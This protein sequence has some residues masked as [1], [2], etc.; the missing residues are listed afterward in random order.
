MNIKIKIIYYLF[1]ILVVSIF[2]YVNTENLLILS[3]LNFK[4]IL[5][6]TFFALLV[7]LFLGIQFNISVRI[8]DIKLSFNEWFGLT[9]INSMLSYFTPFR[10]GI[11]ARA[12][13]LKKRY[14]LPYP[15]QFSILCCLYVTNLCIASLILLFLSLWPVPNI[16]ENFIFISFVLCMATILTTVCLI[17][18]SPKIPIKRDNSFYRV[19]DAI[20]KGIGIFRNDYPAVVKI[21]CCQVLIIIFTGLRLY[22]SFKSLNIPVRLYDILI[23]QSIVSFSM[24]LSITPGNLGIKEGI[25]SLLASFSNISFADA[26]VAASVDRIISLA[27]TFLLGIIF[28]R[29]LIN[30]SPVPENAGTSA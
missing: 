26:V 14:D 5:L 13:Y 4:N 29:R 23:I 21:I 1:L 16:G 19:L 3:N 7:F 11:L 20:I 10:A 2:F 22:F 12:L 30:H 6:I 27:V 28:T 24:I 25:I 9:A 17:M 15:T 18:Y 8:I